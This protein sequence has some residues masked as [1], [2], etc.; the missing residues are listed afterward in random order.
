[1]P[2]SS[3]P[4]QPSIS[5]GSSR[6]TAYMTTPSPPSIPRAMTNIAAD[7]KNRQPRTTTRS[8]A[9]AMP[10]TR[11]AMTHADGPTDSISML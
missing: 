9:I 6:T 5:T 4:R 8:P 10:T 11:P 1:M 7:F 3:F 2:D